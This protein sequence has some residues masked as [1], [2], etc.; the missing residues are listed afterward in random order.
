MIRVRKNIDLDILLNYGFK[1]TGEKVLFG[2][3]IYEY[4]IESN[5]DYHS[6]ILI[7]TTADNDRA[8]R[9]YYNDSLNNQIKQGD[10][11]NDVVW[12]EIDYAI[13]IPDVIFKMFQDNIIEIYE[14]IN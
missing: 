8:L 5:N 10:S 1:K 4:I 9:F 7:N 14:E 13:Q 11:Y 3:D 6:S 12:D 2:K